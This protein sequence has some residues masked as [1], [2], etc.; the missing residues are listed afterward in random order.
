MQRNISPVNMICLLLMAVL[1]LTRLINTFIHM[2]YSIY[3]FLFP[4]YPSL[5]CNQA[6]NLPDRIQKS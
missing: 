5:P 6:E 3:A 4:A 1:M 2:R